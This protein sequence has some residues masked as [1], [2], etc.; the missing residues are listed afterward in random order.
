[1][2]ADPC[3]SDTISAICFDA[4]SF[5]NDSAIFSESQFPMIVL[6][7]LGIP[8]VAFLLL[9]HN[10]H[11]LNDLAVTQKYGFLYAVLNITA[12]VPVLIEVDLP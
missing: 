5:K 10:K 7:V 9:R 6:Y 4:F 11:K 12:I 2:H 1:M 8:V 3:H